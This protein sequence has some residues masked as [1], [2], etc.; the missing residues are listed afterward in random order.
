MREDVARD[1]VSRE[2]AREDYGVV[3]TPD[4]EVDADATARLRREKTSAM[5][6]R[7]GIDVGGTFTDVTAFDEDRGELVAVRK[8]LSDPA[9]PAAVMEHDH[10]RPG[11]RL[12]R[13]IR[14]R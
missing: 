2:A 9:Q 11:A 14:C 8:Y 3:L 5:R 12:R 1:Y 6:L 4:L 7:V 13:R 10:R